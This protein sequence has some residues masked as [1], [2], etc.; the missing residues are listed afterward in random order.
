MKKLFFLFGLSFAF[1]T[2]H[3]QQVNQTVVVEHF[4]N[5]YCSTCASRNPGFFQNIRQYPQVFHLSYHPSSPY[6]QCPLNQHNKAENDARTNFYNIYGSTPRV[7]VNGEVKSSSANYNSSALFDNYL[8]SMS[9]FEVNST[10]TRNLDSYTLRFTMKKVAA[11]PLVAAH[12]Y[13]ALYEDTLFMTNANGE[14]N[15]VNVFRKTFEEDPNFPNQALALP[16]A[17][18]DSIVVSLSTSSKNSWNQDRMFAAVIL[19]NGTNKALIQ[20]D[21]TKSSETLLSTNRISTPSLKIFPNPVKS[22]SYL[23]LELEPLPYQIL[24]AQGKTVQEGTIENQKILLASLRPGIYFLRVE[25]AFE[26]LIVE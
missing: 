25:N 12:L 23:N 16:N 8:D 20:A 2:A 17:I 3:A 22:N 19:Q 26:K 5:T 10:L 15:P 24:D 21:V 9:S 7:V 1:M 6:P 11:S 13:A 4:T 18:G 14:K